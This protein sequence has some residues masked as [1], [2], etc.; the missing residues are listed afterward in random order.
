MG[1]VP[2][3]LSAEVG[4]VSHLLSAIGTNLACLGVSP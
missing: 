4:L 3:S 1:P 2:F